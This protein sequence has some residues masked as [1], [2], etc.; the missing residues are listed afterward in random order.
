M[1]TK[2][3]FSNIFENIELYINADINIIYPELV[4]G[5]QRKYI[6]EDVYNP[7]FNKGGELKRMIIGYYNEK[8]GY[9]IDDKDFK[10][11]VRKNMT[12]VTLQSQ[13]V[14]STE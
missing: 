4:N 9:K 10:Y 11:W 7:A 14:V 5:S 1:S 2:K 12:G 8:D 6:I 13:I 3:N